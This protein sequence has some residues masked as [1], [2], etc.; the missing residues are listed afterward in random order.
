[1][2]GTDTGEQ[3]ETHMDMRLDYT[4]GSTKEFQGKPQQRIDEGFATVKDAVSQGILDPQGANYN[5]AFESSRQQVSPE[6]NPRQID[7]NHFPD[8]S[9]LKINPKAW[10]DWLAGLPESKNIEDRRQ[11]DPVIHDLLKSMG[12][13]DHV[14]EKYKPK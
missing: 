8:F 12:A 14:L 9:G 2:I 5:V 1:M 13:P 10:D 4:L 11:Q 3:Y 7:W 6:T